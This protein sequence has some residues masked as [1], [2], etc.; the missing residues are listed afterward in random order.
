MTANSKTYTDLQGPPVFAG[1]LNDS[2]NVT[3]NLLGDTSGTA[4]TSRAQIIANLGISGGGTVTHTGNL[5]SGQVILGNSG[6]DITASKVAIT[7][8]AT[9]G[10]LVFGTDN[11]TITLQGTDTYIGRATTDTLTNKTF[12]TAGAGNSFSV[13]S[14][15]ITGFTGTGATV[16]MS[17]APTITG[18]PTIEGVT[19]TGATGTGKF[20]FDTSP[21][22]SGHPTIEGVTSTGA[23]GTGAFV[24]AT[25][26]TLVT[27][28]IGA[29]A[30]TSL[31]VTGALTAFS[32]TA[33]PAGGTAGAGL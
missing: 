13:N 2:N 33:P 1:W 26:P 4:P 15:A 10:T 3:Y 18:H 21:T 14:N 16:V 29:A 30:G 27:P 19:S 8:P 11:A 31:A 5:T 17:V 6:V 22:I 9:S 12:N 20:V 28:I 32:G 25:S 23:T 24:F 7:Q